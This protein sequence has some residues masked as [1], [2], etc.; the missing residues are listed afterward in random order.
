M[1]LT[2][3]ILPLIGSILAGLF[4]KKIGVTGSHVV[5]ISCLLVSS[6]LATVAFYEVILCESPVYI[7]ITSWVDSEVLNISW[8]FLFDSLSVA[9]LIDSNDMFLSLLLCAKSSSFNFEPFKKKFTEFYPNSQVPTNEFLEWFIGFSEGDGC[10]VVTKRGEFYFTVTQSTIDVQTLYYIKNNLGLGTIG[11]ESVKKK[12]HKYSVRDFNSLYLLCLLFNGNMVVPTRSAR[13]IIFLSCFN[14]KLLKKNLQPIISNSET[15]LPS[16]SDCWLSG[17]AD[18]EGCFSVSLLKTSNR[19]KIYFILSQKWEV[20]KYV[21]EHIL[22]LFPC[23]GH[24][25]S[26]SKG[27]TTDC[28]ELRIGGLKNCNIVFSYFD[29]FGLKTKKS[30]SY[31]RWKEVHSK[32]ALGLHLDSTTRQELIKLASL[33]NKFD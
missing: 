13:F 8:E 16:L 17:F 20:N 32:L 18:A 9:M 33:I 22:S 7:F 14:E 21:L 23:I 28:W 5:T 4:G 6:I 3:L 27:S 2:I 1:Y 29:K 31:I 15:L 30:L 11:V 25:V 10:F 26:K 12:T 19:F 24:V